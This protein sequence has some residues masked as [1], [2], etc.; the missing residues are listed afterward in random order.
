MRQLRICKRLWRRSL[1]RS[2]KRTFMGP[3]R[4]CWNGITSA[5]TPEEITSK[6]T[7]VSCV[8]YQSKCPREKSLET[9][10]MH[11]VSSSL[12]DCLTKTKEP[13]L[14]FYLPISRVSEKNGFMFFP[15]ALISEK[16]LSRMG[17]GFPDSIS[18]DNGNL[19]PKP[20]LPFFS[21]L[22]GVFL[23]LV[24]LLQQFWWTQSTLLFTYTWGKSRWIY[25]LAVGISV[26]HHRDPRWQIHLAVDKIN[27]M[28]TRKTKCVGV[29]C[30]QSRTRIA[31]VYTM[32]NGKKK[33]G[34]WV[35]GK[36]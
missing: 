26:I 19:D 15:G 25:T 5:L 16:A 33:H 1:T 4:I 35:A 18:Y 28:I 20:I 13:N 32:A 9:Y 34:V 10:R 29:S 30:N 2:H 12:R 17:I 11:L 3:S 23:L 27:K 21:I 24:W 7:R 31:W 8:Y 22:T 14:P 6:G 36:F